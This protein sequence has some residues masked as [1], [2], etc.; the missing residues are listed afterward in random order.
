METRILRIAP[1]AVDRS[2]ILEVAG[3][4]RAGG[5]VAYPTETFYGLGALVSVEKAVRK[6]YGLKKRDRGKPL[7]VILSGLEMLESMA[8]ELPASCLALAGRFWPGPL[9]LVIRVKEAFPGLILGPGHS[10][11]VRVPPVAWL[12][13]LVGGLGV[14]ITAT[15]ANLSGESEL[16]DP[17]AVIE[18]FD[19]KVE[20][21]IDA[22][23]TPGGLPSTVLDLTS[24]FPRVLREGAVSLSE[25]KD[26]LEA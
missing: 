7:P 26:F 15:S 16:A 20:M 22:G 6:I 1:E 21:I 5:I 2:S 13:N 3:V 4:L 25:L 14:P 17:A 19:S 18:L 12:R 10:L 9:T 8:A 23:R 11:G 24:G